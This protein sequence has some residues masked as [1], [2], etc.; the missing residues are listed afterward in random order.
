M[1]RRPSERYT[2]WTALDREMLRADVKVTQLAMEVG[3]SPSHLYEVLGGRVNAS[4]QLINRL[5]ARFGYTDPAELKATRPTVPP[6]YRA[7][8]SHRPAAEVA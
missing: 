4:N 1:A 7:P 6:R 8:R 3:Y 5:A 2:K